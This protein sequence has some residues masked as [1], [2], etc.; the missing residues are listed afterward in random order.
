VQRRILSFI[1]ISIVLFSSFNWSCSKLD[2]TNIGSDQLPAVDNVH[3]FDTTLTVNTTQ[4]LYND[5]S[6]VGKTSDMPVGII[7]NDPLFGKTNADIFFQLKPNFFPY[8]FGNPKDTLIGLDSI[9]LCIKYKGFWGDTNQVVNLEVRETADKM[10]N[11]SAYVLHNI[12][13][14]PTGMGSIIGTANVDPKQMINYVKYN[15]GRDSVN[16]QIRI[17]L[18]PV[19]ATTLFN[20]DSIANNPVNN[21]FYSD[22]IFRSFYNGIALIAKTG[23]GLIYVSLSD[24][25]T[26]LEINY[27]RKNGTV[28]TVYSSFRF[29]SDLGLS[30]TLAPSSLAVNVVRNR[31][32][33]PSTSPASNELY[34]QTSPGAYINLNIP[35]LL[36]FPNCVIHRAEII[37]EQIPTNPVYDGLFSAPSFLYLDLKDTTPGNNWKPLYYDLSPN[38]VY[39]P[40][41][42]S[43]SPYFPGQ[44]DFSY[45]GGYRREQVK[46]GNTIKFYNINVSRYVQHLVTSHRPNYQMRLYAPYN[47]SY[48][49]YSTSYIPFQNNLAFG[50][51]KLGSGTN[52]DHQLRL[53][54]IYS[55]L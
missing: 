32:G 18:F 28:D 2:T 42:K 7:T 33:S 53:H 4:V 19:W 16:N 50:R 45:Y 14:R 10:F 9:V 23:N 27:R 51:V 43:G 26:K 52:T 31:T 37:A 35:G 8:Y 29:N 12:T 13:Y 22:S 11:D 5:T 41:Y 20:R 1:T 38:V 25:S 40:D 44:I 3:T 15:N 36:G 54:I 49:Q 34:L 39:D 21:A 17:K 30:G 47:L 24:T 6:V 48:P 46:A 55:K